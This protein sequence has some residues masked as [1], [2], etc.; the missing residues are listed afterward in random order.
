VRNGT[1]GKTTAKPRQRYLCRPT[2]GSASHSFTP[3]LARDHVHEGNERC[4]HCD[5]HRGVHHGET[6]SAWSHS[7]SSRLVAEALE[8]LSRGDSYAEV[9]QWARRLTKTEARRVRWVWRDGELVDPDRSDAARVRRNGN[10][11][12]ATPHHPAKPRR[13]RRPRFAEGPLDDRPL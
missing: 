9:S 11:I 2:D 12:H 1:Y 8:R 13:Q 10:P 3:A 7:W 4:D 5:E 6:T